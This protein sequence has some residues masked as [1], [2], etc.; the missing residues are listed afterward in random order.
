MMT[1]LLAGVLLGAVGRDLW[2]N[3]RR[4]ANGR[5]DRDRDDQRRR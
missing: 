3:L 5:R 2:P 4:A 1:A